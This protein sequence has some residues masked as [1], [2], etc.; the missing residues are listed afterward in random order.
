MTFNKIAVA[1]TV[2]NLSIALAVWMVPS[3]VQ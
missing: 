3:I 1:L 2:A